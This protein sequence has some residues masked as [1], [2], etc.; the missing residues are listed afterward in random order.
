MSEAVLYKQKPKD[1]GTHPCRKKQRK[2]KNLSYITMVCTVLLVKFIAGKQTCY[3]RLVGDQQ[4]HGRIYAP[5]E[6]TEKPIWT[7]Y[8]G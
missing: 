6:S 2:D 7:L 4:G 5:I 8:T 1:V 3:S